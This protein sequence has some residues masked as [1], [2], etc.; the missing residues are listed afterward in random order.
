MRSSERCSSAQ[1]KCMNAFLSDGCLRSREITPK[2]KNGKALD[3]KTEGQMFE[4]CMF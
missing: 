3:L 4:L 1:I 2:N